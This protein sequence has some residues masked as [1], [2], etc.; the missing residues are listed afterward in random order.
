MP[1]SLVQSQFRD[2]QP[3]RDEPLVLTLSGSDS[4]D[5]IADKAAR[6]WFDLNRTR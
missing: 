3:P 1:A 6:W 4:V 5:D 2:L